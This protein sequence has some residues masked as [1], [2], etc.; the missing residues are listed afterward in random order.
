MP[1]RP[2][3]CVPLHVHTVCTGVPS[4]VRKSTFPSCGVWGF[5]VSLHPGKLT[6]NLKMD[7]RKTISLYN[8]V[9]FRFH[10][11]FPVCIHSLPETIM[12][13]WTVAPKGRRFSSTKRGLSTSMIVAGR[14]D[15]HSNVVHHIPPR[16]ASLGLTPSAASRFWRRSISKPKRWKNSDGRRTDSSEGKT[17]S[18]TR[19]LMFVAGGVCVCVCVSDTGRLYDFVKLAGPPQPL[20]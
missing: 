10:A 7:L 15:L 20:D 16:L 14:V 17:M 18:T 3:E 4:G 11:K 9:V 5:P 8:P 2:H 12:V 6:W 13:T 19:C 1:C